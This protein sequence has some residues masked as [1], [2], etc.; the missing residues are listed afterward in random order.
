MKILNTQVIKR[1]LNLKLITKSL[2]I[3]IGGGG[4]SDSKVLQQLQFSN[5]ITSNLPLYR[6]L[7]DYYPYQ[8]KWADLNNLPYK[9]KLFDLVIV[10]ASLHIICIILT[11][12]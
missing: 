2:K 4:F 11:E 1:A 12:A 9:S 7:T 5:V 8:W 6:N 10:S 3:L